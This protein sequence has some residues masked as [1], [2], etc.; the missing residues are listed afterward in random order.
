[1]EIS[2][3]FHQSTYHLIKSRETWD[4]SRT[5]HENSPLFV[6]SPGMINMSFFFLN[7]FLDIADAIDDPELLGEAVERTHILCI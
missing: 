2:F 3:T 6:K 7:R 5:S 1:M 4:I